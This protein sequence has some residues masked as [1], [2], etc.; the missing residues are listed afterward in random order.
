[1]ENQ[2]LADI[3]QE[4]LAAVEPEAKEAPVNQKVAEEPEDS[5]EVTIDDLLADLDDD[6][7]DAEAEEADDEEAEDEDPRLEETY[8][9]KVDGEMVEVS[10]KEALAGYQRQADYTRKA[11]ALASEREELVAAQSEFSETLTTLGALD[12]AWDENPVQVLAHFAANTDNPTMSLALLI[13]ELA[14]ADMLEQEFLD[15]FGITK[16]IRQNWSKDSEVEN[17][18]R[19]VS[20]TEKETQTKAEE[21]AHE[22]EVAQAVAEYEAQIDEILDAEGLNLKPSQRDAFRTRLANYA[23]ENELTNLKAAYKALKYEESQKKKQVVEKTKER[24]K[25]KKN[26]SVVGRSGS[27]ASGAQPVVDGTDLTEIIRQTMGEMSI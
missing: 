26:A 19:K 17:L 5:D 4:S 8:Q 11:Q 22:A 12:E 1:M 23:Y 20:K 15:M 2:S 24:V 21:A 25:Q 18:R 10:L 27:G 16:E 3:I 13:K 14:S 9:V 6:E 7:E